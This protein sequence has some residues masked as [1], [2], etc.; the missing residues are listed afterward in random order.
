MTS[1]LAQSLALSHEPLALY[2]AQDEPAEAKSFKKEK[3]A[4]SGWGCAMLLLGEA[5]KGKTISFS[6]ETCHCPGAA[7]GL[8]LTPPDH[9]SFPGGVEGFCHFLS[10]GNKFW[11]P[12]RTLAQKMLAGGANKEM[13][14]EF[15]E[16]EGFKKTPELAKE[17]LESLPQIKA[18]GPFVILE[19]L[20]NT[21]TELTPEV[22][23][24]LADAVQISAL[25]Y[26]ANF[27]RK[28]LDNV[29]TPFSS[30]CQSLGML[31]LAEAGEETPKAV[32]GLTDIS[33]R[34]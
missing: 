2:Y 8:G 6:R 10:S 21:P 14:E 16:G 18:K 31:P 15:L 20:S 13:V 27:A 30:G 4:K 9:K 19:P 7:A 23:I 32:L 26:Q 24:M 1:K 12:G 3:S 22:V 5:L 33:A 29:R 25:V 34:L 28:G 11:E 17:Y